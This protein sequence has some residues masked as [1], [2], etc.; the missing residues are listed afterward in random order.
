MNEIKM[1]VLKEK[2]LVL[3]SLKK[4]I[5]NLEIWDFKITEPQY[6]N[7]EQ[8]DIVVFR[9]KD[10]F[11][12]LKNRFG[13]VNQVFDNL[14][15]LSKLL[16]SQFLHEP[17]TEQVK[18]NPNLNGYKTAYYISWSESERGWGIRPDGFSLH[19]KASD[20]GFFLEEYTKNRPKEVPDEYDRPDGEVLKKVYVPDDLYEKITG[21]Y[22]KRFF[23]KL[24]DFNIVMKVE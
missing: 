20:L 14:N 5:E 12:V 23:G 19:K 3:A 4:E 2:D 7:I 17:N 13:P 18:E 8:C 1:L 16:S 21:K 15:H 9:E 24:K 22:G 6:L 10:L 11:K